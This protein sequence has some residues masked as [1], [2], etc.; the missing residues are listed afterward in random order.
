MVDVS[1]E[2][3]GHNGQAANQLVKDLVD[4]FPALRPLA[5]LLKQFM[6][7]KGLSVS[8]TGGLSSYALTLMVARYLQEQTSQMDSGSL[9][10]GFLDFYGNHFDPRL[11]GISVGRSRYFSRSAPLPA[12]PPQVAAAVPGAP[13]AARMFYGQRGR[14][15]SFQGGLGGVAPPGV[16]TVAAGIPGWGDMMR[17]PYRFDPLFIE[18]PMNLSNNV[19]HNCFRV[20]QIQRA[21]SDAHASLARALDDESQ[22]RASPYRL[23][24][25]IISD[26]EPAPDS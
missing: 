5:L 6:M 22:L 21:W 2:G 13:S 18:D 3:Q 25:C 12:P 20:Y 10:L 9:L 19:G 11:T 14:T 1:F 4:G 26:P 24:R 16:P 7:E 23:L 8:Y 15:S 17:M